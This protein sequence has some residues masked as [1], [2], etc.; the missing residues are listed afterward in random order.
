MIRYLLV[1]FYLATIAIGTAIFI[2]VMKPKAGYTPPDV[3]TATTPQPDRVD[4]KQISASGVFRSDSERQWFQDNCSAWPEIPL[5]KASVPTPVSAGGG[6]ERPED[7]RC[8]QLRGRP[9]TSPQDRDF[10]LQNCVGNAPNTAQAP[11]VAGQGQTAPASLQASAGP[12]RA[13]CNQIRGTPYRSDAE[14][15]WF[16]QHCG[17]ATVSQQVTASSPPGAGPDGR[18]CAAIQGSAYLSDAERAWYAQNCTGG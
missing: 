11:P 3:L 16:L 8:A 17:G 15:G 13:D 5:A 12:D 14:R 10:F 7:P 6:S 2:D 18:G 9:Y 1:F 4:C